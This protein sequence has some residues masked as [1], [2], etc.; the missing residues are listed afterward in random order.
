VRRW[1]SG[2]AFVFHLLLVIIVPGCLIAG[3]WQLGRATG[4]NGLSWAYTFEWPIFAVIACVGWWQMI[5]EDPADVVAR[6]EERIRR[7]KQVGPPTPEPIPAPEYLMLTT[8]AGPGM[9]AGPG[10]EGALLIEEAEVQSVEQAAVALDAYN[11]YLATLASKG[12]AKTWRNPQ[13][14]P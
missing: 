8:K 5:H 13:G 1:F 2:R 14:R 4:G 6:K 12:K 11:E 3:W 9:A 10:S 7:A